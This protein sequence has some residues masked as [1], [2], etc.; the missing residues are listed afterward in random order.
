MKT[1]ENCT[2]CESTHFG[3]NCFTTD[4]KAIYCMCCET[5]QPKENL[6]N[7]IRYSFNLDTLEGKNLCFACFYALQDATEKTLQAIEDSYMG[8]FQGYYLVDKCALLIVKKNTISGGYWVDNNNSSTKLHLP[9]DVELIR[10]FDT[11]LK[12]NTIEKLVEYKE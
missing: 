10:Y 9:N 3:C 1:L 7:T 4:E 5:I 2:Y 8:N 12:Y 11:R 6:L